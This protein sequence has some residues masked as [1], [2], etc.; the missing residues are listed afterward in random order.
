[1]SKSKKSLISREWLKE[2]VKFL[3]LN[4]FVYGIE[5][6]DKENTKFY[7]YYREKRNARRDNY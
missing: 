2:F 3:E 7:V 1:M 6:A 4:N 5:A